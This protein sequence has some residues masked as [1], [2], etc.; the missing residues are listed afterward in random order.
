[1]HFYF[2]ALWREYCPWSFFSCPSGGDAAA[3]IAEAHDFVIQLPCC[4]ETIRGAFVKLSAGNGSGLRE[5]LFEE[6]TDSDLRGH[7]FDN[8]T[9]AA[10]QRIVERI[11]IDRTTIADR[12][13]LPRPQC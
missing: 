5:L 4:Y 7:S 1:M 9:E 10:I 3:K 6:P 13:R 2:M 11:T 8:E 12:H